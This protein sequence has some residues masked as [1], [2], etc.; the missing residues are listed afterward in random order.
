[1]SVSFGSRSLTLTLTYAE[2]RD[3][4]K[5]VKSL[6]ESADNGDFIS[7]ESVIWNHPR[8]LN[9]DDLEYLTHHLNEI[10]E[11]VRQCESEWSFDFTTNPRQGS[12][13]TEIFIYRPD[14][15]LSSAVEDID[16]FLDEVEEDENNSESESEPQPDPANTK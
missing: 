2:R 3:F 10:R 13:R 1:M 5:T 16:G 15:C 9:P 7:A 12:R 8:E 11:L 6:L 14:G 4:F